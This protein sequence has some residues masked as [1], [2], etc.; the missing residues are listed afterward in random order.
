MEASLL[1]VHLTAFVGAPFLVLSPW[2]AL[3]FLGVH[4]AVFGFYIRQVLTH[5][6][7]VAT[8]AAADP[9]PTSVAA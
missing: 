9:G 6:D 5:L 3:A 2:Q 1:A 7:G 4:Q 8:G